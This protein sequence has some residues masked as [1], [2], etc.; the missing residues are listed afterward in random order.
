MYYDEKKGRYVIVGEEES[1]DDEPP[2]PP[3]G[4]RAVKAEK[5]ETTQEESGASSLTSVGFAGALANRGRGRG[6]GKVMPAAT[7]FPPVIP[8]VP[9]EE[10]LLV[11]QTILY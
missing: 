5:I 8:S 9:I 3:P 11:N 7:K 10:P 4:A 2:P 6:R 1:E